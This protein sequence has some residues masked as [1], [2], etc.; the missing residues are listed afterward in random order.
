MWNIYQEAQQILS[1][2]WSEMT[3]KGY[4]GWLGL[5]AFDPNTNLRTDCSSTV[6][7]DDLKRPRSSLPW[8]AN[9]LYPPQTVYPAD[10]AIG[11]ASFTCFSDA[12]HL[13]DWFF[14]NLTLPENANWDN[15][16]TFPQAFDVVILVNPNDP[17]D[18]YPLAQLIGLDGNPWPPSN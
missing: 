2:P 3:T 6:G 5:P 4:D 9:Q 12:S 18:L 16:Q 10:Y 11:Q 17:E 14:D 8:A 7:G 13:D 15:L 1:E